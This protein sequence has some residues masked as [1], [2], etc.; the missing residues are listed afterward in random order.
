MMTRMDLSWDAMP[1]AFRTL[2]RWVT[3]VQVVGYTFSLVF[4][5]HTTRMSASGVA[6]R[7]RGGDPDAAEGAMQFPKSFAEMLTNTHNHVLSM[8]AIFAISGLALA[9]CS[10]PS[11]RWRRL[12]IA[13]PFAAIIVS[14]TAMW[15]MRYVEPAFSWLL[16][17]SS[18]TAAA[19]FYIQAWYIFRE[20]GFGDRGREASDAAA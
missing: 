2:G 14:F 13:E 15:L 19:A 3:A 16:V 7:Y 8:A 4:V 6:T 18:G 11:P 1:G 9:L 20:L 5:Y 17:F 10:R 12:L